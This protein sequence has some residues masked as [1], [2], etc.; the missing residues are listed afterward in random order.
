MKGTAMQTDPKATGFGLGFFVWWVVVSTVGAGFGLFMAALW[1]GLSGFSDLP[2]PVEDLLV[3]LSLLLGICGGIAQALM[4]RRFVPVARH[5]FLWLLASVI[6]P[7]VSMGAISVLN[8]GILS[9]QGNIGVLADSAVFGTIVGVC[10]GVVFRQLRWAAIW[11]V[12]SAVGCIVAIGGTVI[13]FGDQ[14][15]VLIAPLPYSIITGLVLLAL[16][17]RSSPDAIPRAAD[18]GVKPTGDV[19]V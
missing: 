4:L 15:F 8:N 5:W 17:K 2:V 12:A 16:L 19:V 13:A 9:A 7:L 1:Y 11:V 18:A 10:Q 3:P 6:S 14:I